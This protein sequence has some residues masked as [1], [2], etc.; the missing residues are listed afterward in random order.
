VWCLRGLPSSGYFL[1]FFGL[2]ED[3]PE[4]GSIGIV[5]VSNSFQEYTEASQ[6][7]KLAGECFSFKFFFW[8]V[9]RI[10]LKLV[11]NSCIEIEL[12]H[13]AINSIAPGS[14][15]GGSKIDN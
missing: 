4:N 10:V 11:S 13:A 15:C 14:T 12:E 2:S 1:G 9:R 5:A 7:T 8:Q 3:C 6:D